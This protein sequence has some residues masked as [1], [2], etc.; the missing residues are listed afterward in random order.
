MTMQNKPH[1]L[2][3]EKG[4]PNTTQWKGILRKSY[5]LSFAESGEQAVEYAVRI[6]PDLILLDKSFQDLEA[7]DV[8]E[9]IRQSEG[10]EEVP[11]LILLTQEECDD[12]GL[13]ELL[14]LDVEFVVKPVVPVI[15]LAHIKRI[16][17]VKEL[18]QSLEAEME[19]QREQ[20]SQ[21]S[22]QSI[23]T[24][25]QT[26]DA[27][28]RYAKGHSIRVA[29][30]C[31]EIAQKLGW[32]KKDTEN[33]YYIA[34]LHDIGNI[35]VEDAVLNKAS[36][37][38]K[39][40]FEQVKGHTEVGSE[41]VKNTSFIHGVEDAVRYHHEHYDGTGYLGLSGE[42]I[43]L[44]ARIIAVADAYE[45]M[46]SDRAYRK[47]MTEEEAK[48][49]LLRGRGSQFDPI[50][51]D[52]FLELLNEGLSVDVN[53]AEP[54]F[55][56]EEAIGETGDLLRQ[57]FNE[58][59]QEAQTERERDS[60][61]GF[62]NRR[63]F[64]EKVNVFLHHP[65]ASG[66]FFMMDLDNFKTVNDTYGHI[67]GDE[68]IMA[69]A[70][71]IRVNTRDNDYVCRIGGDEFAI[72][73]P[74]LN[75]ERVIRKRAENIIHCFSEKKME[76]GCEE[77]SVSIGIMTKY[78]NQEKMDCTTLYNNAD[79]A[80]YY[81]KNNGKDDYHIYA[82]ILGEERDFGLYS[83]QVDLKQLMRRVEERKYRHGAYAVEYD[84]F[85]YIYQFIVRNIERSKQ[86]VQIILFTLQDPNNSDILED[87]LE[88]ALM[89]L[90]TA[91]VHSLRRGDVT[92]RLSAMQ[93]I[94]VLMDTNM[95][96]GKI[97]ADRIMNK[98]KTLSSDNRFMISYDI[99]EVPVKKA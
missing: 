82:D 46:T 25:A 64:E 24:I 2:I 76:L 12:R 40:E 5:R 65:K 73:F 68:L 72:F 89:I 48:K 59:V 29:L 35:A 90:E 84:R 52:T 92:T 4:K 19:K 38:T 27:R 30:Y 33:L 70:D 44:A 71:V 7:G 6:R 63:Y 13:E 55:D 78:A 77:C 15:L 42:K 69:F 91:V 94:V 96:N 22:L 85:A 16:L 10:L 37:L 87:E 56:S 97:V 93:Q 21:L 17:E 14:A 28:D 88:D 99:T 39:E 58:T 80:L 31:R 60:L 67:M 9:E 62:L 20:I 23:L 3:A 11:A 53:S 75:K 43:P 36:S 50:F 81:V 83:K 61:T 1:L 45:A 18:R 98:Y 32:G 66:T 8:I 74:E 54:V 95:E 49:E 86:E 51:V 34:L 26:V 57:V 41:M 47:K 79:K